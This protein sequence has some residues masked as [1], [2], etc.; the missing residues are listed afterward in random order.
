[1]T[2]LIKCENFLARVN[3]NRR[4]RLRQRLLREPN[5]SALRVIDNNNRQWL[6]DCGPTI[7]RA[8]WQRGGDIN[9]ID[10]IYFTHVHP[11]HCTGLTALLN[12]W[13]AFPATSR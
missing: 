6:I 3:E 7:P 10:A 2:N 11:D 5:T 9:D 8:L 1:M 12:Y 4:S 13:K